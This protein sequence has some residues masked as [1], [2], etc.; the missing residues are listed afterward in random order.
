MATETFATCDN[1]EC[2]RTTI[3]RGDVLEAPWVVGQVVIVP[4]AQTYGGVWQV[5]QPQGR[6]VDACCEECVPA[7]YAAVAG[8]V[9]AELARAQG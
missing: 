6:R 3:Y 8:A 9:Y 7:A 2:A 1:P 5:L 4:P